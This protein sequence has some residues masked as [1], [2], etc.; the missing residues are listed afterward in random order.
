MPLR[1][2]PLFL[3]TT[4]P[5]QPEG[6]HL[7]LHC[8]DPVHRVPEEVGVPG[9]AYLRPAATRAAQPCSQNKGE[10]GRGTPVSRPPQDCMPALPAT[11]LNWGSSTWAPSLSAKL[12]RQP[13][14]KT[15][16]SGCNFHP[17]AYGP[18]RLWLGATQV[19]APGRAA[20]LSS[21][22]GTVLPRMRLPRKVPP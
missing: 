10:Q 14:S 20:L 17:L 8:S 15:L 13:P 21:R 16:T 4:T 22:Q 7:S 12:Q 2:A 5:H 1:L 9:N 19:G 18:R 6:S 11:A 3:G